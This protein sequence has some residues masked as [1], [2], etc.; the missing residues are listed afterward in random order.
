MGQILHWGLL[1]G[2]EPMGAETSVNN[3]LAEVGGFSEG[4]K[5][6]FGKEVL[7]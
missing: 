7:S 6:G 2:R 5:R 1:Q 3:E 4:D